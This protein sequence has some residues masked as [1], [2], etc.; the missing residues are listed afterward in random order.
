MA[1]SSR[2]GAID[3]RAVFD[4][5]PNPYLLLDRDLTIIGMN[6]AFLR[7]SGKQRGEILGRNIFSVFAP[8]PHDPEGSR[9]EALQ[10]SFERVLRDRMADAV[11]VLRHDLP[12]RGA[13]NGF[14]ERYWSSIN[15]P[16]FDKR[17]SEVSAILNYVVDATELV[18]IARSAGGRVEAFAGSSEGAQ[19]GGGGSA[20]LCAHAVQEANRTLGETNRVLDAELHRLHQLFLRAPGYVRIHRGPDHI[21]ELNNPAASKVFGLRDVIGKPFK[22]AYPD[23]VEQGFLEM[24]D[25][26]YATGRP[27]V[28]R[29][30]RFVLRG[31]EST[32]M[33][34]KPPGEFPGSRVF[35][36]NDDILPFTELFLTDV[37]PGFM[38]ETFVFDV[39]SSIDMGFEKA[40]KYC[41]R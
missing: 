36:I 8:N 23:L 20:F 3:F 28:G 34:I 31:Q 35:E 11:A 30:V 40:R 22:E 7:V 39:R 13:Q 16:I 19:N 18:K 1:V 5:S 17:G 12:R 14:E 26:V 37:L 4:A 9:F 32:L 41:G 21:V 38:G 15:T 2:S 27:Y 6:K 33:V 24:L 25:H 29:E 10:R